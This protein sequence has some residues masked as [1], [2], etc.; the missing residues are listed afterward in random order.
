MNCLLANRIPVEWITH[1]YSY[2]VQ[3]LWQHLASNDRYHDQYRA[4]EDTRRNLQHELGAN[5]LFDGW[6]HPSPSDF[7]CLRYLMNREEQQNWFSRH[8]CWWVRIGDEPYPPLHS[9][10]EGPVPQSSS[11]SLPSHDVIMQVPTVETHQQDPTAAAIAAVEG[12]EGELSTLPYAGEGSGEIAQEVVMA[13]A[14]LG[15]EEASSILQDPLGIPGPST[16]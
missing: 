1:A 8:S 3:Y 12:V 16:D 10:Q 2:G 14:A 9:H 6:Y 4:V 11:S 13:V 7:T 15:V 5:P